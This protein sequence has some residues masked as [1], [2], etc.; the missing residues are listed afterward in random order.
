M[1]KK[2]LL[3]LALMLVLIVP[4]TS[5]GAHADTAPPAPHDSDKYTI[6]AAGATFPYP[7]IDKWRIDYNAQYTGI[8]LNYQAVGSGAGVNLF[9]KKTVDFGASDAPLQPSEAAKA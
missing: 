5:L 4:T 1:T 2:L 8:N 7:L 6:I 3:G 9:T